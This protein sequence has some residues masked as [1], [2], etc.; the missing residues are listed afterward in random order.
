[1]IRVVFAMKN[2]VFVK[3][4]SLPARVSSSLCLFQPV[5]LP[6]CVPSSLDVIAAFFSWDV[7]IELGQ[8]MEL[9]LLMTKELLQN[10]FL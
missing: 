9:P 7:R 2:E 10:L 3:A 5:S 6:A 4:V 1:M 8:S